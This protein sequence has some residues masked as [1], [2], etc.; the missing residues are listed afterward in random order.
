MILKL[1]PKF[2]N[3]RKSQHSQPSILLTQTLNKKLK[4]PE[5]SSYLVCI[6][7]SDNKKGAVY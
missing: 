7:I 5:R 6:E 1:E 4:I 3:C 2:Q